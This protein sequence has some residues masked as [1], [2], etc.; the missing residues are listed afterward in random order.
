MSAS[1][2]CSSLCL[3]PLL[4][5]HLVPVQFLFIDPDC[6]RK[7]NVAFLQLPIKMGKVVDLKHYAN[8]WKKLGRLRAQG[9]GDRMIMGP[10]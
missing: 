6:R 8:S 5:G 1:D 3:R 9:R 7:G 2:C 10:G 4:I